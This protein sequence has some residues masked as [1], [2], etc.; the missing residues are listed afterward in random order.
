[1][2]LPLP[3][4]DA[5]KPTAPRAPWL[6]RV[7]AWLARGPARP[8]ALAMAAA[9]IGLS[10]AAVGLLH[11]VHR[12]LAQVPPG[13]VALVNQEPILMSD[14][15]SETEQAN[16]VP[17][18]QTTPAERAAVL[19][20][21]IDEELMVQRSL[22]LDL[23]EQDTDVRT[24]LSD[25]VTSL[26]TAPVLS[27]HPTDDQLRAFYAAHRANYATQGS[28]ALTDLVLHIG[29]FENADQSLDQAMADAAQAVYE[30]RSGAGIEFVKQHFAFTDTGRVSGEEPDFAARLHLGPKLYAAADKLSDGEVSEPVQDADGV[31]VLVMQH[32]QPPVFTDYDGVRNNVYTDYIAAQKAQ[33]K[34][35]NLKVLRRGAQILVAPGQ[36]E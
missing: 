10:A 36:A 20:R 2:S 19:R 8:F 13:D 22:A 25:G 26:V 15:I 31:H 34:Q 6:M 35:E 24:A 27:E 3:N 12:D 4:A 5:A 33:A 14:F 9:I 1:M 21:M 16:G 28:M 17:F 11:P 30:L 7:S 29:G 18:A 32:R 23:P